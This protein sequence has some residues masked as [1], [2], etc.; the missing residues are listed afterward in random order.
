MT[1]L[2]DA[3]VLSETTRRTPSRRVVDWLQDNERRLTVDSGHPRRGA[4]RHS[5]VGAGTAS[6]A[7]AKVVRR[8]QAARA[9]RAVGPH[10]AALGGVAGASPGPRQADAGQGQPH[11]GDR[12][13]ARTRAGDSQ[14]TGLRGE[15]SGDSRSVRVN[16]GQGAWGFTWGA[17]PALPPRQALPGACAVLRRRPLPPRGG[18][19]AT[20]VPAGTRSA[21]GPSLPAAPAAPSGRRRRP[22]APRA[23]RCTP[24]P[25]SAR[26]RPGPDSCPSRWPRR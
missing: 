23:C 15:R 11:R 25:A 13:R 21:A 6:P 12:S 7:P 17:V 22:C 4:L 18:R 1:Y 10:R 16:R 9:L 5:P 8:R 24:V 26:G 14:S 19:A 2:V 3:N 20:P